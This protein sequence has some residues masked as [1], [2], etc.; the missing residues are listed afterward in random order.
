MGS[1]PREIDSRAVPNIEV[2]TVRTIASRVRHVNCGSIHR[3]S[4]GACEA[5]AVMLGG[6]SRATLN[7]HV[8]ATIAAIPL[9][10]VLLVVL[11]REIRAIAQVELV[12]L[13][14]VDGMHVV[15]SACSIHGERGAVERKGGV[16]AGADGHPRPLRI[17]SRSH[18]GHGGIDV[19]E[20][21]GMAP[22]RNALARKGQGV[23]VANNREIAI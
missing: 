14:K 22:K 15:A 19:L 23:S 16:S 9:Q 1:I 12:V 3:D 8:V 10:G 2:R 17:G 21:K 4:E 6:K 5:R 11:N 18:A 13:A 7:V 20:H